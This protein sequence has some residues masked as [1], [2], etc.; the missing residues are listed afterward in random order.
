[1][2][3]LYYNG[4]IITVNDLQPT[5]EALLVEDGK[6]VAVGTLAGMKGSQDETTELIDL[7]GKTLLPGFID[8]HGHIGNPMAGLPQLYPP[9]NGT[10]DSKEKLM[11]AL[12]KMLDENSF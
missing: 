10:V 1:M 4:T 7:D 11:E 8:G 2:K 3:Q 9:P 12:K 5:A 6:I